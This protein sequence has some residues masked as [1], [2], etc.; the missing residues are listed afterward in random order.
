LFSLVL[1]A[2]L[3]LLV[4]ACGSSQ[5]GPPNGQAS[6][7]AHATNGV[8][9]V[10]WDRSKSSISGSFQYT[11]TASPA[12]DGTTS[13]SEPFTGTISGNGL[14]INVTPSG[15]NAAT[16]VGKVVSSGFS[17]SYPGAQTALITL[18]FS[19]AGTGAYDNAVSTLA[20]GEYTSPCTIYVQGHDARLTISGS[21]AASDC[22]T[23]VSDYSTQDGD[24]PWTTDSQS[25]RGDL[26][27]VCTLTDAS[28]ENTAIVEDDGGQDY[29]SSA[30]QV[31][32]GE[33]WTSQG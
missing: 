21:N 30:C 32:R 5:I 29:G 24:A 23:F 33:A 3:A 15:G 13:E 4:S 2:G 6:F 1:I 20:D 14:T 27:D 12:G 28:G 11:L 8:F 26:T 16:Y 10:Q 19:E 9:L 17:L 22:A 31:L 18:D 7:V 25:D